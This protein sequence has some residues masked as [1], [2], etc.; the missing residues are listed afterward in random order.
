[1]PFAI[2]GFV[3]TL[4]LREIPLRERAHAAVAAAAKDSELTVETGALETAAA[5]EES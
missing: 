4:F 3:I 2:A 5:R 1:M